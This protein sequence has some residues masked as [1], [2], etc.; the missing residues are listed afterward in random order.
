MNRFHEQMKN[1]ACYIYLVLSLAVFV[2]GGFNSRL[3]LGGK[4][5][6]YISFFLSAIVVFL[7]S[8]TQRKLDL[9]NFVVFYALVELVQL[10]LFPVQG[11]R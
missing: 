3:L 10:L 7:I 2:L 1:N 6:Y 4:Y 8:K 5:S 11:G 9:P